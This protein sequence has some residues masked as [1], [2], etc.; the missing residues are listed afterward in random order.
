[1][2]VNPSAADGLEACSPA[3]V[4][5][6]SAADASCPDGSR[7]GSLTIATPLLDAPL[8]GGVYLASPH[9]N[10]FGALLAVYLVAKG[11]GLVVK[12]AGR[13]EAD[14]VSGRLTATFDD[15]PQ[16]RS[17]ACGCRS[18]AARARCW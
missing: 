3:Q 2:R 17:R 13:V 9:E 4:G 10:P 12:L 8:E 1:V 11:P 5:L 6:H 16:L 15:L 18:T 7:V 14:P